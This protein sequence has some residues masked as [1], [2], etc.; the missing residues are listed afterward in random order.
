[1]TSIQSFINKSRTLNSIYVQML[2][3]VAAFAVLVMAGILFAFRMERVHFENDTGNIIELS[4]AEI[5]ANL[6]EIETFLAGCSMSIREM[7]LNGADENT[8]SAYMES[9]SGQIADNSGKIPQS[10]N[11]RGYFFGTSGGKRL[12]VYRPYDFVQEENQLYQKAIDAKGEITISEPFNDTASG[13]LML[14]F[15]V[16]ITDD[17]G[18]PLAVVCLDTDTGRFSRYAVINI[19][20][21]SYGILVNENLD[22]IAHK[23]AGFQGLKLYMVNS[24]IANFS[25][26]LNSG[27]DI[28]SR[29]TGSI[30]NR[31]TVYIIS[32]KFGWNFCLLLRES[33]YYSGLYNMML[34]MIIL[35]FLMAF[36]LCAMTFYISRAK[37]KSDMRTKQKSYFLATVSHEIRTPLNAILGITEIQMQN[38]SHTPAA[39]ESFVKINNSG[40]L[41]LSIIND[42]LDMSKIESGKL[43]LVP[44]KYEVASLINDIIQL[45]YIRYEEKH[46]EFIIDIDENIP[47]ILVGDELRIKQILNNLLS[48]AFKYTDQGEV[49]FFVSAE[50]IGRGGGAV[51]V[52]LVFRVEDTGQGMTSE[53]LNR[54]FDEYTRFNMEANRATEGAGLGMTITRNLIDL[55]YGNINVKSAFGEGTAVTV[56][57]PQKTYGVGI[58]GVI[59]KK[60]SEN[61]KN[62]RQ[63]YSAQQKENVIIQEY[64]P[65]GRILIVDDVETNLYVAQGLMAPYGL[66]IDLAVSG[67]EAIEKIKNGNVYDIIFMDHM[68]PKMDGIESVREIRGMGYTQPIVALT[69]N[70]LVGRED[71]FLKSGFDSFISKPIDTR[72][73]NIILNRL[74]RDKQPSDILEAAKNKKAEMEKT[75]TAQGSQQV[76]ARLAEVFTN[77]A[78]KSIIALKKCLQNSFNGE[79]DIQMYIINTHSMKSALANIGENALSSFA[80]RL[81]QAG[82]GKNTGVMSA[83]TSG[84]I[85]KLEEVVKRLSV[86]VQKENP[87]DTEESP[88]FLHEKLN[89]IKEACIIFDKK[90]AKNALNEL[91][92][93]TWPDDKRELLNTIAEHLLHS[94]FDEVLDIIGKSQG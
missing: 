58:R 17:D 24:E 4:K 91:R 30:F 21:N 49:R 68:M 18:E 79:E 34:F 15:A 89:V 8:L 32:V 19:T 11:A 92:E 61:L 52:T 76:Q 51:I 64:M 5:N 67:F 41:L 31:S 43:E 20:K 74:I 42:I 35:G 1:M 54:L 78:V 80:L 50:C 48:N 57:L 69:A 9:M 87:A 59:G 12:S 37:I 38:I 28:V 71:M 2:I 94:E 75:G 3:I 93:K 77:D 39:S 86:G 60:T 73:L 88:A 29:K 55:M 63:N 70:A 82:R 56:R 85:S 90:T 25:Y 33:E 7:L 23:N 44:V 66:S 46:V 36:G 62:F 65:Y 45:N 83:E 13:N 10:V 81:E 84:F 14:T 16:L 40:K 47:S 27:D 6:L 22:I 72:L 26:L 53:Q